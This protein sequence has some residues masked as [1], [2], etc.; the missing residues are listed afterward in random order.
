MKILTQID[1]LKEIRYP[2]SFAV[3]YFDG[4]HLGHQ[5]VIHESVLRA[6]TSL[7]KSVVLT[8]HPHPAKILRPQECPLLLTSL[9]HKLDLIKDLEVDYFLM[10]DFTA[11][12]ART[13]PEEFIRTLF[14]SCQKLHSISMGHQ[15]A[16]GHQR[17]GNI[18][19]IRRLGV[20]LGFDVNE[21]PSVNVQNEVVSSTAIRKYLKEGDLFTVSRYL[22]RPYSILGEVIEGEKL[23]RKLGFPTANLHISVELLP[24]NGV[25]VC[26]ARVSDKILPAVMNIGMRPTVSE[27]TLVPL[28][29]VHILDFSENIYGTKI[30]VIFK[31][32]LRFEKKFNSMDELKKQIV[33][34][35]N[36]ARNFLRLETT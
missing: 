36:E 24:P 8:F 10:I 28:V 21:V 13:P 7:G 1:S 11:Q 23:G 20:E 6:Q 2:L 34:D 19:L 35:V 14:H 4:V 29:E 33:C 31:K 30:E 16:F 12:F 9:D 25:Y 17:K 26:W 5:A 22:G 15:W 27:G 18:E 3:G 32:F